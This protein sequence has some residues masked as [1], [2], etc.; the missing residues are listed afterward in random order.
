MV[1][2]R[3]GESDGK[4]GEQFAGKKNKRVRKRERKTKERE[5]EKETV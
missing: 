3:E 2:M 1:S 4:V 5:V